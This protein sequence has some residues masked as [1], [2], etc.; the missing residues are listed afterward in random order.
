MELLEGSNTWHNGLLIVALAMEKKVA[1]IVTKEYQKQKFDSIL[2]TGHSAGGAIAQIFFAMSKTK[3][4]A[5]ANAVFG[6]I[7]PVTPL[8]LHN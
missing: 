1:S 6:C 4:S 7:D 5:I 2:F 3:K 8:N